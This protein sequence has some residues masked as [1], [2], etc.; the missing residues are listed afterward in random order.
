MILIVLRILLMFGLPIATATVWRICTRARWSSLFFAFGAFAL[1]YLTM[2]FVFR[3]FPSPADAP[4]SFI[5]IMAWLFFGLL[6]E[7]IRWLVIFYLAKNVRSWE[8]GVMFGIGYNIA[9]VLYLTG[10]FTY[11]AI[12]ESELFP[13]PFITGFMYLNYLSAWPLMR[14]WA[15][16]WGVDLL[17]FNVATSVAVLFSVMRRDARLLLI[18]IVLYFLRSFVEALGYSIQDTLVESSDPAAHFLELISVTDVMTLFILGP[19][20]WLVFR[21]REP[22]AILERRCR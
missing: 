9:S 20:L 7:G 4:F 1:N 2:N 15:W 10:D 22:M 13:N 12:L 11:F 8:E 5:V 17:I 16:S 21:L 6:R 19:C 14:M 3:G 18:P